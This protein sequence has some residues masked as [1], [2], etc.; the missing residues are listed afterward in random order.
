MNHCSRVEIRQ[1][2]Y[3]EATSALYC[4]Q[5]LWDGQ[6]DNKFGWFVCFCANAMLANAVVSGLG[7]VMVQE[8]TSLRHLEIVGG[9]IDK[10]IAVFDLETT[11]IDERNIKPDPATDEPVS[12]AI[13]IINPG[14][15]RDSFYT[16]IKPGVPITEA[17]TK[18]HGITNED[19]AD[20]PMFDEIAERVHSML[21]GNDLVGYG[22]KY[23][24]QVIERMLGL[25]GRPLEFK[26]VRIV[27]CSVI[28]HERHRRNLTAAARQ[29]AG[30]ELK[31]REEAGDNAAHN[32]SADVEATISVIAGQI[33]GEKLLLGWDDYA[34]LCR[35]ADEV[36]P[37]GKLVRR[38]DGKIAYAFGKS[39]GKSI[40]ED[41]GFGHWMLGK[42]FPA[43][44]L[45]IVT[46]ELN[47][48]NGSLL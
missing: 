3:D 20:A 1:F 35:R 37:A 19:V 34:A 18:I 21:S 9:L 16:L 17:S 29:F 38:P 23:D 11:G 30:I 45:E 46:Q 5:K 2:K 22:V 15:K 7:G 41:P 40:D 25:S 10:P 24:V 39:A 36:D 44:T 42:D 27:D 6:E 8:F 33:L 48:A 26:G 28:F 31:S 14:G 12:I 4:N 32:A 47:K 13:T 43:S